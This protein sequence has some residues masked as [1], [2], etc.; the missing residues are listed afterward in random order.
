MLISLHPFQEDDPCH[1][2][3]LAIFCASIGGVWFF[4]ISRWKNLMTSLG[5][6]YLDD[7]DSPTTTDPVV[8]D[9]RGLEPTVTIQIC[10]YNESVIVKETIA[11]A[12]SQDWPKDRLY[13]QVC[14]DSTEKESIA[15]IENEILRWQEKG[16]RVSR[17]ERPDRI[18][19]KAGNLSCNFRYIEGDFV[20]YLD[21][22]HQIGKDFLR[23]TIPHF[24]D[25]NGKSKDHVGLVQTPWSYYNTHQ[26]LLTE[27]GKSTCR[28]EFYSQWK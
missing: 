16:F 9:F 1:L 12:C 25:S 18:G 28:R 11:R 19:F 8:E 23:K 22:D 20:A 17:L 13:V 3:L 6:Y 24:Y 2:P 21:A 5:A 27:C 7:D 26:N 14:D 10:A 15:I 4:G